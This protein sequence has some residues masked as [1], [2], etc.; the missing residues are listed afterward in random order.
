MSNPATPKRSTRPWFLGF[1]GGVCISSVFGTIPYWLWFVAMMILIIS[2]AIDLVD[3]LYDE[4]VD[5]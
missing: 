1:A 5:R 2:I 4:E 3:R